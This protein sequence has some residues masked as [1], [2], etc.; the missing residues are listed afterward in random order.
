LIVVGAL[1]ATVGCSDAQM[2]TFV[3][4]IFEPKRTPQQHMLV[5]FA[6]DDVDQRREALTEVAESD[7]YAADWAVKGYVAVALLDEDPQARCVAIRALARTGAPQATDVALKILYWRRHPG[8]VRRPGDVCRWDATLA[9]ADLSARNAVPAERADEVRAA[10]L[11]R[12]RLD[13]DRFVRTAAARGLGYYP[14][15][16]V[17]R[18]LIGGLNDEAFVVVHECEESLVRLTGVTHECSAYAWEQW[19]AARDDALFA[20]AGEVPESRQLPYD[21]GFEKFSY[22]MKRFWEWLVP[23]RKE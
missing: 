18:A 5:A 13:E 15:E 22:D 12:L 3:I 4:K 17:L 6:G 23:A 9:L 16:E 20:H 1:S 11:D 7:D 8:E 21:N 10:L 14:T 19:L 2:N